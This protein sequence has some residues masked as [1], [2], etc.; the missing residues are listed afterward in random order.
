M[1]NLNTTQTPQNR[2]RLTDLG[3]RFVVA[4]GEGD[5]GWMEWELGFSICKSL[6]IERINEKVL[7][8][9]TGLPWWLSGKQAACYC[10][11]HRRHRFDP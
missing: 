8:Y 7:L 9:R 6:H 4:K 3:D 11:K 10:R 2:N 1:W 5:G